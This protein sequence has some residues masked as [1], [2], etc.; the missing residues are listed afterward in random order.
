MEGF[1]TILY[2][3]KG[4]KKGEEYDGKMTVKALLDMLSEKLDK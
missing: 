3:A 2:F 1:P 4:A